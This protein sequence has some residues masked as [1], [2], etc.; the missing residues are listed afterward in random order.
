MKKPRLTNNNPNKTQHSLTFCAHAVAAEIGF[1]LFYVVICLANS[2]V[3]F[4]LF[5][6]PPRSGAGVWVG[7]LM[8]CW[9]FPYLKIKGLRF[10]VCLVSENRLCFQKIFITY[11]QLFIS[12][13]FDRYQS[14]IHVVWHF[15]LT[16]LHNVP[17]PIFS[18]IA[19]IVDSQ[20]FEI[21]KNNR[22]L[23]GFPHFLIFL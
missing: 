7:M 2:F 8:G 11:Y 22:F 12:C 1:T 17:V 23:K 18:E 21:C 6:G 13:F 14:H 9:G 5:V 15:V 4:A 3:C 10:L 19:K 16:D 20:K